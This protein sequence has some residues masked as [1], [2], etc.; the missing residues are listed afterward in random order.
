MSAD[1]TSKSPYEIL[2]ISPDATAD[3]IK[4]AFRRLSFFYHPDQGGSP[5]MFD[6]LKEAYDSIT[7]PHIPSDTQED[8]ASS[9]PAPMAPMQEELLGEFRKWTEQRNAWRTASKIQNRQQ[10]DSR[11]K[12][13]AKARVVQ[14]TR[15]S[16]ARLRA[17]KG[18]L[19]QISASAKRDIVP[20]FSEFARNNP[21]L[22]VVSFGV[23]FGLTVAI[24]DY[25]LRSN[26]P[27]F[28]WGFWWL[29]LGVAA[30]VIITL[31]VARWTRGLPPWARVVL[32]AVSIGF[33]FAGQGAIIVGAIML[34]GWLIRFLF[35]GGW[36]EL[37]QYFRD[38]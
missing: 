24:V 36:S 13:P 30:A 38:W 2:G 15:R 10:T 34:L 17:G 19:S 1:R 16:T 5:A 22:V 11:K 6:L 37:G 29:G 20:M 3:E 35:L 28:T 32:G 21:T 4:S 33:L 23:S 31:T 14:A 12:G 18:G 27:E 26:S 25:L 9:P 8:A 7:D